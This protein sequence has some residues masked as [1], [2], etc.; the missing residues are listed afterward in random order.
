MEGNVG[1]L[2]VCEDRAL[3]RRL[4]RRTERVQMKSL[5]SFAGNTLR[6][7]KT[8]EEIREKLN[9][10]NLNQK[11]VDTQFVKKEFHDHFPSNLSAYFYRQNKC[12]STNGNLV[13]SVTI[14]EEQPLNGLYPVACDD[15]GRLYEYK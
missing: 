8:K 5:K 14:K 7:H 4:E 13:M 9:I 3:I 15:V 6:D 2:Y 12:T 1:T 10:Y 11:Q